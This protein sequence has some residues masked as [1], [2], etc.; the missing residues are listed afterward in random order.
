[1]CDGTCDLEAGGTCDYRCEGSCEYDPGDAECEAGATAKCDASTSA[2]VECEGKCEGEAKPPEVSAEC[3]AAVEAK[4]SA[5][6]ECTPP[7]L[8]IDFQLKAGLDADAR[9]EFK[10]FLEAFKVRFAGM[11]AANAKIE[12]L[13]DAV[14]QVGAAGS[15]AVTDAIQTALKGD[16][17]F[18]ALA[19]LRCAADEVTVVP[20]IA[21]EA[22][23]NLQASVSAF[24]EVGA[25][26]GG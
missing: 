7:S 5:E 18:Q 21:E 16:F 22:S 15:G 6:I 23:A 1:M 25:V 19:G 10:A 12:Y 9:A 20:D 14:A 13:Q 3:E 2:D 11:I 17:D 4:A 8:G 26:V 24:V